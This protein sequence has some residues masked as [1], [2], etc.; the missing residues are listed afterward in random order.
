[1]S[2]NQMSDL[3]NLLIAL[4][5]IANEHYDENDESK[6]EKL[7]LELTTDGFNYKVDFCGYR[8]ICSNDEQREWDEENDCPEPWE[9]YIKKL[10][11]KH[12]EY[13]R[14]VNL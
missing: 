12:L 4:E 10:M 8:I 14:K 7:P 9:G 2:D 6:S 1:M 11:K 3:Q 5:N 13:I